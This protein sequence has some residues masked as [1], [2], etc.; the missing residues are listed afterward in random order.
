MTQLIKEAKRFQELAGI[1]EVKI[2]L[3]VPNGLAK[4]EQIK[5][6]IKQTQDN[7]TKVA[8]AIKAAELVLPIWK[9]YYPKDNRPLKAI[10]AAKS[11]NA[12]AD[13]AAADNAAYTNDAYAAADAAAADAADNAAVDAARAAGAAA[14]AATAAVT[15]DGTYYG[16]TA[17]GAAI[18][19]AFY[20]IRATKMYFLN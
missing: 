6:E 4:L 17:A 13:A 20:A 18:Y 3:A 16:D 5:D 14:V 11:G 7:A 10:Q 1:N 12:A 2:Q 15:A 9:Y 8:L 19:A